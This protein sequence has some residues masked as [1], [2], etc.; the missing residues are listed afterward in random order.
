M[1]VAPHRVVVAP[2]ELRFGVRARKRLGRDEVAGV[3]HRR[4]EL[5]LRLHDRE[6]TLRRLDL[7]EELE[8]VSLHPREFRGGEELPSVVEGWFAG[9]MGEDPPPSVGT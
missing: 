1:V 9:T 8:G 7:L 5:L 6:R 4:G 3:E 2:H